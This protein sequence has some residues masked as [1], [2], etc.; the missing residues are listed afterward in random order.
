MPANPPD[1][2]PIFHLLHPGPGA[3]LPADPNAAFYWKGV[4]HLYYMYN[5]NTGFAFAHIS[6]TDLVHWK[7][8]PT[9]L[10]PGK[11]G[12]SIFS[13][14]GFI[15]KEGKPAIIYHGR[16]AGR[17][18]VTFA[19]DDKLEKWTRPVPVN[20]RDASG[21]EPAIRHWDPDC[22]LNGDTYYAI[23]GGQN[24]SLMKSSDLKEWRYMGPL[25]SDDYPADLDVPKSEDIS[26]PNM[27]RIGN[28][29]ML[30][31]IS[32]DLG[33]RYYLGDFKDEKYL[34]DFHALMSW[35]GNDFISPESVLT[36]D[37]R[38]VMWGWLFP[39]QLPLAP[40]AVFSLPRELEL[41]K[42]GVLRIRPLREL[43][44]LR[45]ERQEEKG[46]EVKSDTVQMLKGISGN[47][48]EMEVVFQFPMAKEFGLD[49]LC[50]TNGENGVRIAF[51]S[52]SKILRVGKVHAPFE[53]KRGE[54]L[55]LRVFLDKNVV[56]VF[57]NDRQAAVAVE[58]YVP[59]NLGV[60]L[61]S[62]QGGVLVK[63]LRAWKMK[64]IHAR[65]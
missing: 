3:A 39:L 24:P 60:N 23:S 38:R 40:P 37:G 63:D 20:P 6:S 26:C 28:K 17:N 35:N 51:L 13:G 33:T 45:Y 12:H 65:R 22:W 46:I 21:Q 16:G 34:P 31:C 2:W 14:T 43:Q 1:D 11:M 29:W 48:L 4:Y 25:L 52:E 55:T 5:Y 32:H 27:F 54:D 58:K 53:L 19:L 50:D 9:T 44:A 56:E 41:P 57:A 59:G 64:S 15:T 8:H 10:F 18:Q 30:L 47:T 36:K 7:W 42:D 49:V 62:K 61:F